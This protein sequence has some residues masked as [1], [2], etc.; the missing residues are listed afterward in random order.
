MIEAVLQRIP[1]VPVRELD[2]VLLADAQERG[3]AQD[4]LAR[5]GR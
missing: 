2:G 1:A 3:A 5:H 4:W